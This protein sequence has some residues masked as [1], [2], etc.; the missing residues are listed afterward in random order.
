MNWFVPVQR[1]GGFRPVPGPWETYPGYELRFPSV[2]AA[3]GLWFRNDGP[4]AA[5]QIEHDTNLENGDACLNFT[6]DGHFIRQLGAAEWLKG[7]QTSALSELNRSTA[8][9]AR[10]AFTDRA[11]FL[12]LGA[13]VILPQPIAAPPLE[14]SA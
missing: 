12:L 10:V 11:R 13:V 7:P 6:G 5:P 4:D 2:G 8:R 1:S 9:A 3:A 14:P